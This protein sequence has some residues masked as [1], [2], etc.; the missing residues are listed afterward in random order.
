MFEIKAFIYN[1]V[2]IHFEGI[3]NVYKQNE[4]KK[5]YLMLPWYDYLPRNESNLQAILLVFATTQIY[6]FMVSSILVNK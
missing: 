3:S 2:H 5:T 6:S 1:N 4:K